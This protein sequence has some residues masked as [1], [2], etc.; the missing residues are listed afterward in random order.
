MDS[1]ILECSIG[2]NTSIDG[3]FPKLAYYV[4]L[5]IVATVVFYFLCHHRVDKF[6]SGYVKTGNSRLLAKLIIFFFIILIVDI[7]FTKWKRRINI[8]ETEMPLL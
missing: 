2:K 8:A 3:V 4:G 5:A 6:F 7:L 1:A